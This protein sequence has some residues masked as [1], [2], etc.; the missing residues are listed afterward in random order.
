MTGPAG[1][2][3]PQG[4]AGI[5]SLQVVDHNGIV[6]GILA[7]VDVPDAHATTL[8]GNYLTDETD[9]VDMELGGQYISVNFGRNGFRP[10][11]GMP[12]YFTENCQI[13]PNTSNINTYY[14]LSENDLPAQ[15]YVLPQT[16]TTGA[17]VNYI[18]YYPTNPKKIYI[19]N[20]GRADWNAFGALQVFGTCARVGK[21]MYVG[22]PTTK[23]VT[24]RVAGGSAVPFSLQ[25]PANP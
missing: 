3:G 22:D 16:D 24:Q 17:V 1:P 19:S 4:P 11:G 5:G 8:Y 20:Q 7:G 10:M 21:Y 2:T 18:L 23:I 25:P 14:Y 13:Y 12:I 15:G 9:A 6:I